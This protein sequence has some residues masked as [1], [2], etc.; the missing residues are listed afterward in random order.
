MILK[1]AVDLGNPL[2]KAGVKLYFKK[3]TPASAAN[4]NRGWRGA[5]CAPHGCR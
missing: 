2:A 4:R 3:G 5:V 1:D